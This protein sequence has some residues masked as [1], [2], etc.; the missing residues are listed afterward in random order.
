[1]SHRYRKHPA[2]TRM[3]RH[4]AVVTLAVTGLLALFAEGENAKAVSRQ[5]PERDAKLEAQAVEEPNNSPEPM[6]QQPGGVWG[7][8]GGTFGD[9]TLG[10]PGFRSAASSWWP[11]LSTRGYSPDY[12]ARMTDEERTALEVAIAENTGVSATEN[13]SEIARLE[14]ASRLRSGSVGRE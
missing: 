3:Y 2:S 9:A 14:N 1:M 13:R 11:Q 6:V 5:S 12:L 4:F 10:G 8:D 7:D